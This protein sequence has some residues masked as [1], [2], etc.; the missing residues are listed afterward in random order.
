MLSFTRQAVPPQPCTLIYVCEISTKQLWLTLM[1]EPL[2]KSRLDLLLAEDERFQRSA[3]PAQ[4]F[5]EHPGEGR[6][7]GRADKERG[8]RKSDPACGLPR[9]K[10]G[11]RNEEHDGGYDPENHIGYRQDERKK[12]GRDGQRESERRSE[13]FQNE[14]HYYH[15]SFHL[16]R[17][18]NVPYTVMLTWIAG[19]NK[20]LFSYLRDFCAGFYMAFKLIIVAFD[21]PDRT[22]NRPIIIGRRGHNSGSF[23]RFGLR[24]AGGRSRFS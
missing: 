7:P 12:S 19:D 1:R 23:F 18:G 11:D 24:G 17:F 15:Q 16:Q 4:F 3:R 10:Q 13:Q 2:G 6:K 14:P 5:D 22:K 21:G 8:N 9:D 20:G